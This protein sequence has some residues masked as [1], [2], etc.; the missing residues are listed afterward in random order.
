VGNLETL[1][2]LNVAD[3]KLKTIPQM[4]GCTSLT[5]LALFHN[6]IVMLPKLTWLTCLKKLEIYRSA[7]LPHCRCVAMCRRIS[8]KDSILSVAPWKRA[9]SF[10]N[11]FMTDKSIN[12]PATHFRKQM[13]AM[14]AP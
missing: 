10:M 5:R 11:P 4:P 3:N 7:A 12:G 8:E 1:V 2:E 6:N 13:D 9:L 14:P